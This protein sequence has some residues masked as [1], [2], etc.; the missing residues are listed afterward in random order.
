[1]PKNINNKRGEYKTKDIEVQYAFVEVGDFQER[2]DG[3]FDLV[4][5]KVAK[6]LYEEREKAIANLTIVSNNEVKIIIDN[7]KKEIQ[8]GNI[9][10]LDSRTDSR[11]IENSPANCASVY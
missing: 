9:G 11:D 4:F 1:M 5:N 6:Q 10:I 2:V 3:I 8:Y 7:N